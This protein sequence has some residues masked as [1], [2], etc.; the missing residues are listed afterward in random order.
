[1]FLLEDLFD[2]KDIDQDGKKFDNGHHT[3]N[4]PP[5]PPTPPARAQH[6]SILNAEAEDLETGKNS[7]AHGLP[8]YPLAVPMQA[9]VHLKDLDRAT[10]PHSL[11]GGGRGGGGGCGG[12]RC[13]CRDCGGDRDDNAGSGGCLGSQ[14]GCG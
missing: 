2:V 9:R 7:V 3:P 1:M 8:S 14:E 4:P 10:V 5:S 6:L 13:W 12:W 11:C